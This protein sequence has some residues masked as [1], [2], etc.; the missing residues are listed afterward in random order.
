M[1]ADAPKSAFELAMEK[2]RARDAERGEKPTAKL[3]E[4]KKKEI[5]EA[6]LFYEAKLA[7]REILFQSERRKA[8][9]DPEKIQAVEEAYATDRRRLESDR[10]ARIEKIRRGEKVSG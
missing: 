9:E 3:T 10:D 6:R 2:L 8:G 1:M 4:A 5:A 7:E